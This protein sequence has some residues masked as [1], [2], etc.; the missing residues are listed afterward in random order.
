M[1]VAN[2]GFHVITF[3]SVSYAIR[4]EKKIID[5]IDIEKAY[6]IPTPREI[7]ATCGMA[8]RIDGSSS[9]NLIKLFKSIEDPEG[10]YE[11]GPKVEGKRSVQSIPVD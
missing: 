3:K 6:L 11:L 5:I 8:L 1:A 10:L 7:T 4:A 2:K 9:K